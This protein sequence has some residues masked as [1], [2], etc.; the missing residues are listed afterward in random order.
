MLFCFFVGCCFPAEIGQDGIQWGQGLKRSCR[1]ECPD[2]YFILIYA[3]LR[4][5]FHFKM[6]IFSGALEL[7][8]N[9]SI[10]VY[11]FV[12]WQFTYSEVPQKAQFFI[13]FLKEKFQRSIRIVNLFCRRQKDPFF[14]PWTITYPALINQSQTVDFR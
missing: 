11:I 5:M 1:E 14:F 7:P 9:S 4:S 13:L 8:D 3:W 6:L 12:Y 10:S 2:R